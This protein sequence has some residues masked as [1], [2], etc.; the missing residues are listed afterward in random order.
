MAAAGIDVLVVDDNEGDR[1]LLR[2][3]LEKGNL[4]DRVRL[5]EASDG[6]EAME[7]LKGRGA[8]ATAPRP[9]LVLLDLNM[10]GKDG[11]HVLRE[12]RAD[13]RLRD[14]PAVILTTSDSEQE[15][16]RARALGASGWVRKPIDV[17]EYRR[18][19][20]ALVGGWADR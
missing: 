10:P 4:L 19:V 12:M 11:M 7:F 8:F 3:A 18:A 15:A 5:H 6:A 9:H 17:A 14:I 13:G 16:A 20:C 1:L 2:I